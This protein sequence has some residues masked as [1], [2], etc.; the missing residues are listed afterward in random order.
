MTGIVVGRRRVTVT[1]W[2][3]VVVTCLICGALVSVGRAAGDVL[4]TGTIT[5]ASGE[6]WKA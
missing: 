5:S 3:T 6:T 4:L 1:F 2:G